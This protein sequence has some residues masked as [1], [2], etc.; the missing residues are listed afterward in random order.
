MLGEGLCDKRNG[1]LVCIDPFGIDEDPN[2]QRLYYEPLLKD[3]RR[4]VRE[5]FNRNILRCGL[6]C[7]VNAIQG[8]S[9]QVA[10]TWTNSID[11]LFI[12]GNHEY[13]CVHRDFLHLVQIC[14]TGRRYRFTR[15]Q[16]EMAWTN[17][18][19]TEDLQPP[20]LEGVQYIDSLVWAT[21]IVIHR[22]MEANSK[23]FKRQDTSGRG[24]PE[25]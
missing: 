21:K 5:N 22:N 2:Y 15:C 24:A 20:L 18:V 23:T 4:T 7:I 25:R 19:A 9:F 8:Y 3:A 12:D 10:E 16:P 13:E 14:E 11:L 17:R 6:A 1:R